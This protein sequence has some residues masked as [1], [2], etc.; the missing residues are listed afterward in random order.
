[1]L[2]VSHIYKEYK[3][4]P[5]LQDVTFELPSTGVVSFVG[6]N[7]SG[8]TTLLNCISG[9]QSISKGKIE[10]NNK[11]ILS[12][13][14]TFGQVSFF[15]VES[16]LMEN[17]SGL[18]HLKLLNASQRKLAEKYINLFQADIFLKKKVKKY[19]LGM[20]QI[21]LIIMT[22]AVDSPILIFDEAL[23]GLDPQNRQLMMS[24]INILKKEKLILFSSHILHDVMELSNKIIFLNNGKVEMFDNN[25]DLNLN[26][27]YMK[28]ILI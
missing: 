25:A 11:D 28:K 22:L 18:E 26:D 24:E 17:L 10:V 15:F 16:V 21:L 23:N 3:E 5:V 1:M 27:I 13:E 12:S 6:P 2:K 14:D 20:K 4:I 19:S 7:G 9:K 8:K